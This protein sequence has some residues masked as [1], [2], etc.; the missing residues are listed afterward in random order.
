[1]VLSTVC[2][3]ESRADRLANL[4]E[5]L[6]F[7]HGACQFVGALIQ[8]FKQAHVLN[9]DHGLISKDFEESDLPVCKRSDLCAA[10]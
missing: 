1:M 4:A 6:E 9:G 8:F 10:D 7:A 3:I 2:K 5:R